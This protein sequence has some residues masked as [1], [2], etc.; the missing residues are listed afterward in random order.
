[1]SEKKSIRDI[2]FPH[3]LGKPTKKVYEK[4]KEGA[5][6]PPAFDAGENPLKNLTGE[7]KRWAYG[8]AAYF[9]DRAQA[10]VKKDAKGEVRMLSRLTFPPEPHLRI[11]YRPKGLSNSP[12]FFGAT[13]HLT[14]AY[15][16]KFIDAV[17]EYTN[18]LLRKSASAEEA[19]NYREL[20]KLLEKHKQGPMSVERF[21]VRGA[22]TAGETSWGLMRSI[23]VLFARKYHRTIS[24]EEFRAIASEAGQV[25]SSLASL[26][27]DYLDLLL[28]FAKGGSKANQNLGLENTLELV[29][30]VDTPRGPRVRFDTAALER[31]VEFVKLHNP[32]LSLTRQTCPALQVMVHEEG[33]EVN[34]VSAVYHRYLEIADDFLV[35]YLEKFTEQAL[36]QQESG[37]PPDVL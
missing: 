16:S 1:M 11:T 37:P 4:V 9:I 30:L 19:N 7:E 20:K 28:K 31:F 32:D 22:N 34:L 5:H 33:K 3:K 17:F 13:A 26:H 29:E 25:A 35:P 15:G 6:T 8:Y 14:Y 12:D 18:G 21:L 10:L 2:L 36:E 23:P 27:F 24:S